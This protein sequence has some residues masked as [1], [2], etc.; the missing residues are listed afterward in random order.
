[1]EGEGHVEDFCMGDNVVFIVNKG[2]NGMGIYIISI[3]T[4]SKPHQIREL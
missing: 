2:D 4:G 3:A 1:M